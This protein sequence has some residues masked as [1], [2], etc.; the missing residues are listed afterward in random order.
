VSPATPS[1]NIWRSPE[2]YERLNR[3]ADPDGLVPAALD[4]MIGLLGRR[5]ALAVDVG[6]GTGFHL[7]MLA[8][9]AERVVGFEPHAGLAE[10]ASL[11]VARA[12]LADRVSVRMGLA[13]HLGLPGASVDLLFSHWAYFFGPGCE[14][15][16]AEAER[17]L[18]PGGVQVAVDL[19]VTAGTGYARWFAASGPAVRGDRTESFFSAWRQRRLPVV[20]R[21][22]HRGDL[23]AVLAIEFP[24][25]AAAMALRETV[26]ATIAVPTV[27]R[28]RRFP[29]R[30][31]PQ[32][33]LIT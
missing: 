6:C 33:G 7:P 24:P 10:A 4:D 20:W 29:D 28:W 30:S 31:L 22:P 18:R 9:R 15:G 11:R 27:L 32:P 2:V 12:R 19:D 21:F 26:G 8:A 5:V 1:P 17:V 13:E 23:A 25:K 14:T 3:A 16:L